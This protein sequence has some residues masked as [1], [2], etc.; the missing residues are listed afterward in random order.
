MTVI[1]INIASVRAVAA[2][3][4]DEARALGRPRDLRDSGQDQLATGAAL[5]RAEADWIGFLTQTGA[6][7]ARTASA[8]QVVCQVFQDA[9][10]QA[11]DEQAADHQAAHEPVGVPAQPRFQP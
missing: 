7:L 1:S 2:G 11:A 4:D 6:G 8:L 10:E 9:D 3:L 5:G